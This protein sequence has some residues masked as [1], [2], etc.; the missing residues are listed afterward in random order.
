MRTDQVDAKSHF[1]RS[2]CLLGI[3][4][5]R[6]EQVMMTCRTG[7]RMDGQAHERMDGQ[8]DG[9]TALQSITHRCMHACTF[10]YVLLHCCNTLCE[11]R[12]TTARGGA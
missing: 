6:L 9:W 7:G 3:N 8:T 12:G 10:V 5:E 4:R 1:S 2:W 11:L